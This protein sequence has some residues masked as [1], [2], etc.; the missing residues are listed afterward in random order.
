MR[1]NCLLEKYLILLSWQLYLFI[2]V[3]LILKI[4]PLKCYIDVRDFDSIDQLARYLINF[5]KQEY[6]HFLEER[7]SF[8]QSKNLKI[9][10]VWIC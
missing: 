7:E 4:I 9:S 6:D 3:L 1:F 8:F 10:Q 5:S 2:L